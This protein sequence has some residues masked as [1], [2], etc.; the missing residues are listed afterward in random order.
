MSSN[1]VEDEVDRIFKERDYEDLGGYFVDIF[2][3]MEM[4]L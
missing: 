2:A 4:S 1:T 3:N